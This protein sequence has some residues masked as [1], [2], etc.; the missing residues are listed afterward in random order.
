M[1]SK[2]IKLI[3]VVVS[4]V[5]GLGSIAGCTSTHS[6]MYESTYKENKSSLENDFDKYLSEIEKQNTEIGKVYEDSYYIDTSHYYL[7]KK[8]RK[9]LPLVMNQNITVNV[10][11]AKTLKEFSSLMFEY[12]GLKLNISVINNNDSD[13]KKGGSKSSDSTG[14]IFMN[15]KSD[16]DSE[17]M[18][19]PFSFDGKI[20]DMIEYVMIL[21]GLKWYYDDN[22]EQIFVHNQSLKTFFV[23]EKNKEI[24]TESK[25]TTSAGKTAGDGVSGGNETR[26]TIK[27]EDKVWDTIEDNIKVLLSSK[28]KVSFNPRIG[29]ILVQDNDY[30]LSKIG[31]YIDELNSEFKRKIYIDVSFLNVKMSKDK[32]AAINWNYVNKALESTALGDFS[33]N[34]GLGPSFESLS[35]GGNMLDIKTAKGLNFLAGMLSTVGSVSF[36][37]NMN[38]Q[39]LNNSPISFQIS[40]NQDYIKEASKEQDD[41]NGDTTYSYETDTIKDGTTITLTP[42]IIGDEILIDYS[43]ALNSHDGFAESPVE[44]IMLKKESNK[45]INQTFTSRNGQTNVLFTFSKNNKKTSSQSPFGDN[46]WFIGG[47]E[48]SE[49]SKEVVVITATPYFDVL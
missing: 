32:K 19:Q 29:K 21:N 40:S 31:H 6:E 5:I 38:V 11:E 26:N 43:L 16:S 47:N 46:F 2:K 12:T 23:Y 27:S 36:D 28:G 22:S 25:L 13:S 41:Q 49:G 17:I 34:L 24:T 15:A 7:E 18:I 9:D 20:K 37:N 44:E 8:E 35:F 33:A 10:S 1:N 45:N 3:A 30:V 14:V 42:K 4:S 39:T 48:S